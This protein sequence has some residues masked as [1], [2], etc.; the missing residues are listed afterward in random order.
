MRHHSTHSEG[1]GKK[2]NHNEDEEGLRY[3]QEFIK[4]MFEIEKRF[5]YQNMECLNILINSNNLM[6]VNFNIV[7]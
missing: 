5:N 2:Q 3:D 6:Y 1:T 7:K 4:I